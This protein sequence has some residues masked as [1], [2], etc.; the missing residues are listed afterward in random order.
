MSSTS[1]TSAST[2]DNNSEGSSD[3]TTIIIVVCVV[4]A[5]VLIAGAGAVYYFTRGGNKNVKLT[6]KT[7]VEMSSGQPKASA[8]QLHLAP[9][10]A[11]DASQIHLNPGLPKSDVKS[12]EWARGCC[13]DSESGI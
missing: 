4:G 9:D 1:V 5:V 11:R 6:E 10:P 8:V 13:V 12:S 3:T 2:S 7:N